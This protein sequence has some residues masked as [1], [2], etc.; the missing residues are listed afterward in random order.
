M[1][2]SMPMLINVMHH[3]SSGKQCYG[4]NTFTMTSTIR[5]IRLCKTSLPSVFA[6]LSIVSR[7]H[8]ALAISAALAFDVILMM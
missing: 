1:Y 6:H 3:Q 4:K 7:R 5:P 8:A 2:W